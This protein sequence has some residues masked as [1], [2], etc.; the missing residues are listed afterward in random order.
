MWLSED[1][2][3]L[4][5]VDIRAKVWDADELMDLKDSIQQV[6]ENYRAILMPNGQNHQIHLKRR[7]VNENRVLPM[8][9]NNNKIKETNEVNPNTETSIQQV[10][11]DNIKEDVDNGP[12]DRLSSSLRGK[13]IQE[14]NRRR[15]SIMQ[16]FKDFVPQ[17]TVG[18]NTLLKDLRVPLML[19]SL[20]EKGAVQ[21]R[22]DI[23]ETS[24]CVLNEE[25]A[26]TI[27]EA[28]EPENHDDFPA[29]I[30]GSLL[31]YLRK[32]TTEKKK[33]G[34][35]ART[36]VAA[37]F[38]VGDEVSDIV[39]AI[40]FA[41]DSADL[42]WAA[43]LMFVF[44]GL[45]RSV[46]ALISFVNQESFWRI[47]EALI[48][49]KCITDSYRLVTQGASAM[50]G[51]TSI[52]IIRATTLTIGL[53]FES[54]P[55]MI[56]QL[57]IVLNKMKNEEMNQGILAAQ[58]TSV[59]ASC[60]SIGL[61]FASIGVDA[62]AELKTTHPSA[63]RDELWDIPLHG[64]TD[65]GIPELIGDHDANHAKHIQNYKVSD[66]PWKKIERWLRS[67]KAAFLEKPPLWMTAE[68]F[69]YLTP[70]VKRSVWSE[71]G[72]LDELLTKVKEVCRRALEE[73]RQER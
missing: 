8:D 69:D 49:M 29:L 35:I 43:I 45:N 14:L 12:N 52:V 63:L 72:E 44:M 2:L 15:S 62:A 65:W 61:S 58:I 51:K 40:L 55:Q 7:K 9:Q 37:F 28:S 3:S 5:P 19:R 22:I 59:L 56:L 33:E 32:K 11:S 60:L 13:V 41:L 6:E 31:K 42:R 20:L 25:F 36:I 54:L 47:C 18:P 1:W 21:S 71:P 39:L 16:S 66:L 38:E 30:V 24:Y 4:I 23:L 64:S 27:I 17:H 10:P 73:N 46:N 68:W 57:S 48:G 53:A 34:N 67:K 26:K 70:E 50:S